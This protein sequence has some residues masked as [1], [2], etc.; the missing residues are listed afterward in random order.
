MRDVAIDSLSDYLTLEV[1]LERKG[2]GKV[3]LGSSTNGPQIAGIGEATELATQAQDKLSFVLGPG[4]QNIN[5]AQVTGGSLHGFSSAYQIANEMLAELDSLAFKLV[6]E[7]NTVHRQG[8]NLD[9]R[10]G[11]DL[12][13]NVDIKLDANPTNVGTGSAEYQLIDYD[14]VDGNRVTFSFD[15]ERDLWTGRNDTGD[16]VGSGREVVSLPGVQIPLFVS[17]ASSTSSYTILSLAQPLAC[18]L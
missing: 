17:R 5:T 9:G 7:V 15:E 10:E 4:K 11:G 13:R 1:A 3:T 18:R 6:Q 14:L 16:V 2:V 12:F 8:I